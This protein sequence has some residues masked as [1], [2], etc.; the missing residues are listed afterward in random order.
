MKTD[1]EEKIIA[2]GYTSFLL[3]DF[4]ISQLYNNRKK[5]YQ[6]I[7]KNIEINVNTKI[8]DVGTTPKPEDHLN[9]FINAYPWI[10]NIT[11]LSDQDCDALKLKYDEI[12]ILS[13]DARK[14]DLPNASFDIVHSHA[15][16]E[17]IGNANDQM[18]M[19]KECVRVA[20]EKVFIVTPNRYFPFDFHTKLPFIHM[21]PKTIHRKI[22]Y[23]FGENFFRFEKN[24]NL[25]SK[26]DLIKFC[27]KSN[28]K[29]YKII[30]H[31]FFLLPANLILVINK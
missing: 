30:V 21:L 3:N 26:K 2:Q 19:I 8:L 4:Y 24:L 6:V 25:L 13:G 22:L 31:K 18:D 28:I 17:H 9:F 5:I 12:N 10:K 27:D 11:C 14:I 15:T 20:K 7:E 23:L 1:S 29:K 16:I